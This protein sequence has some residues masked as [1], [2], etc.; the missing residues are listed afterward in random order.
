[1]DT[2]NFKDVPSNFRL[3]P[4]MTLQGD[5]NVGTRSAAMYL[6]GGMLKGIREAMREP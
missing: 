5:N 6:L 1:V 2:S 3:I 4:G